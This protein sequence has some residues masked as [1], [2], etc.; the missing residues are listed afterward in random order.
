MKP[1]VQ[2][3]FLCLALGGA[4][5]AD[6]AAPAPAAGG[7]QQSQ[8]VTSSFS[9]LRGD[10][11]N[12]WM[13]QTRSETLGMHGMVATSQPLA[14]QAGLKILQDGGNAFDAAVATAAVI[15]V[16]EPEATG[17]GGDLF[18]IAWS[19]KDKKL[20]ALN[21]SGRSAAAMSVDYF[22]KK[23]QARV[24]INGIDAAVVP[25]AVDGWD[26]LL[27]AY[28]TM[29]FKQVLEPAVKIADEGFG[30]SERIANDWQLRIKTISSDEDSAKVYLPGGKAPMPYTIFR[31]PDLAHAF[32]VLQEKGR[33]AFYKG[34][35][36]E[37][38]VAKSK[39]LGG[40]F[41]MED[42]AATQATWETPIS[43]SYHGYDIYEFP[44]NTQ[45]L[46]V[47][48]MLNILEVCAP[49][50]GLDIK[51]AGPRSAKY[52]HLIV[53]AKKLAY[54]DLG[55]YVGDPQFSKIPVDRLI[56][57]AYA[58]E[59]CAKIDP[60]KAAK[61]V[62]T[63]IP[64][65]GTA[66]I[67]TADKDGNMVSFIYSVYAYFGGGV[68]IPGYGFLLNNRASQFNL[69]PKSPNVIEPRKRPFQTI[70]PGFVMKDGQPLTAF[71]LMQ[72]DQQA[73]GHAQVLVNMIDFDANIQAASDAARFNH[74]QTSNRLQLESAL[75]DV[76]GA[77]MKALGHEVVSASGSS[78]GG[79]QA[80]RRD[81]VTGLLIGASDHRKDG[82]AVGY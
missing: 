49:K 26:Q 3:S 8:E 9:A 80:I 29:N 35:I 64:T 5:A 63:P 48:Q 43:T 7:G 25:G 55:S 15:N 60:A 79:Y 39:K 82:A 69:T 53:E 70:I 46:A 54:T 74:N 61:P 22:K 59:Q 77:E 44:P 17:I 21:G 27:K 33:D 6:A 42:L 20:I 12:G 2:A 16:V 75:F 73:Q 18:V 76:I 38:I 30:V 23:G 47:L 57:K 62:T 11:A 71:G 56:S 32:R 36:A 34:E 81:P 78:M 31:N 24:P 45:G 40:A 72:G 52:W 14:A 10:R 13:G 4:L 1:L 28:G 66:Y 51:A 37:A 50:M 19:A 41:T 58:A 65:G 67:V 68:T